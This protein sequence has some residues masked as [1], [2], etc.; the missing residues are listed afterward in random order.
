MILLGMVLL[1]ILTQ[2]CKRLN[3]SNKEK[4]LGI[5]MLAL[6]QGGKQEK[7]KVL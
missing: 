7:Y 2:E 1:R 6:H 3:K 5:L 4:K